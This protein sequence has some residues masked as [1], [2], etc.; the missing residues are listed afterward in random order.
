MTYFLQVTNDNAELN[1]IASLPSLSLTH[2]SEAEVCQG[3]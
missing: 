3:K 2:I 1:L